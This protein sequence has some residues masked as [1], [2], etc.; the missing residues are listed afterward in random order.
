MSV[1]PGAGGAVDSADESILSDSLV[2]HLVSESSLL[3]LEDRLGFA[4]Q[5]HVCPVDDPVVDL[6]RHRCD[7]LH[8]VG[9]L[10]ILNQLRFRVAQ[11]DHRNT[12]RVDG[13]EARQKLR[14]DL[15]H[16]LLGASAEVIE[17]AFLLSV[18]SLEV[19][20]KNF[21]TKHFHDSRK[22]V[23]HNRRVVVL[24]CRKLVESGEVV[25]DSVVLAGV[26]PELEEWNLRDRSVLHQLEQSSLAL[27]H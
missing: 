26:V 12:L 9:A 20:V 19:L 4:E 10:W 16:H 24:S 17:S 15:R 18:V 8:V 1:L 22:H 2:G 27:T 23:G 3:A 7:V 11:Q 6:L 25:V 21:L 14:D 13:I 5:D